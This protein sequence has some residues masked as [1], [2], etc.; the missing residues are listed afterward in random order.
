MEEDRSARIWRENKNKQNAKK[1]VPQLTPAR[2]LKFLQLVATMASPA[3]F[4]RKL[5]LLPSAISFFKTSFGI[6]RPEEA[7]LMAKALSK[8][9]DLEKEERIQA[10]ILE[11]REAEAIAQARLDELQRKRNETS[12][13]P[14]IDVNKVRQEDA[15]RNKRYQESKS[16]V[17]VPKED[18]RLPITPNAGSREEQIDRFRRNIVYRGI[19]FMTKLYDITPTQLKYEAERLKLNINWDVVKR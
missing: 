5:G 19:N 7:R 3:V 18:W 14:K 13:K 12:D 4:E 17:S 8:Q 2:K 6:E 9:I 11:A 1:E 10:M 16:Q 15:E